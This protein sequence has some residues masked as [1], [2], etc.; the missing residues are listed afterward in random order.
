MELP[1]W[2]TIEFL[3]RLDSEAETHPSASRYRRSIPRWYG[4]YRKNTLLAPVEEYDDMEID[5]GEAVARKNVIYQTIN[6]VESIFLKNY[7]VVRRT[8]LGQHPED[9]D[10]ADDIDAMWL[11]SWQETHGQDVLASML[12]QAAITGLSVSK[13]FWDPSN[14]LRDKKG[15]IGVRVMEPGSIRFDPLATNTHR[16]L[17][18]RYIIHTSKELP[19]VLIR[20]YKD[21][22]EIAMGL[23]DKKGRRV[24]QSKGGVVSMLGM[25]AKELTRSWGRKEDDTG[26]D[27]R[28]EVHE[29]WLNSAVA[30]DNQLVTGDDVKRG[31]YPYGLVVTRINNHIVKFRGNPFVKRRATT[32]PDEYGVM[33]EKRAEIGHRR[34]PFVLLYWSRT[35]DAKGYPGIYDCE[36]MVEPMI[37]MQ[38][39]LDA[40]RRNIAINARTTANPVIAINEDAI[41]KPVVTLQWG[42]GEIIPIQRNYDTSK[43]ITIYPGTPLPS[44]IHDMVL[45]EEVGMKEIAGL[46]AGVVGLFPTGGGTSHTPPMTIG[47]LQEAAFGPLWRYVRELSNTL[48][49]MSVLYDGLIQQFYSTGMYDAV[50]PFGAER[51][52][53]WT[54]RHITANFKRLVVAG[55]TTPVYD[56][57]KRARINE[58]V[59]IANQAVMGQNPTV[60]Q[61]AIAQLQ[62]MDDPWVYQF[63]QILQK[64]LQ[65]L[66]QMQQEL[67]QMGTEAYQGAQAAQQALPQEGLP[68]QEMDM[69]GVNNV[70]NQLGRSPEQLLATLEE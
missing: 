21:E 44:Y 25:T 65:R 62:A 23:R 26:N 63:V 33:K 32:E 70:A 41:D 57:E 54:D 30:S 59:I 13:I 34:H 12:Q 17:D 39:N 8:P 40:T 19:G 18:C 27:E 47:S 67:T 3:D 46:K 43:A 38:Y 61:I 58:V 49:D 45:Q 15:E 35:A 53:E 11:S 56:L 20:R 60:L 4:W 16:G 36:G 37:P 55:A 22:A 69:S 51:Q 9:A 10:L 42:A 29:Y 28:I 14:L 2:L 52:I 48:H 50:S 66:T 64:E 1:K 5:E 31:E 68:E 24:K 6:E 7:P